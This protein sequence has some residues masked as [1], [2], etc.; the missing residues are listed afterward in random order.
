MFNGNLVKL[1]NNNDSNLR[2]NRFIDRFGDSIAFLALLSVIGSGFFIWLQIIVFDEVVVSPAQI[3][4][5][6]ALLMSIWLAMYFVVPTHKICG[7]VKYSALSKETVLMIVYFYGVLLFS[8]F[9]IVRYSAVFVGLPNSIGAFLYNY[10]L[11]MFILPFVAVYIGTFKNLGRRRWWLSKK[12]WRFLFFIALF[13]CGLQ[14]FQVV[15]GGP[16]V[17]WTDEVVKQYAL[18]GQFIKFDQIGGVYRAQGIYRSPLEAGIC[19]VFL[20]M[21]S[22]ERLLRDPKPLG[23]FVASFIC[24]GGVLATG[25]RTAYLLFGVS[26][27]S[28][29]MLEFL[30]SKKSRYRLFSY[31]LRLSPIFLI[32]VYFGFKY[33]ERKSMVTVMLNP[34]NLLIRLRNWGG[35]LDQ[36]LA[37]LDSFVFGVGK[38][39]NGNYGD[40]HSVVIDNTYIGILLTSG[41]VGLFAWIGVALLW[42]FSVN[43]GVTRRA[44]KSFVSISFFVG[45]S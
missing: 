3:K 1:A 24:A 33:L 13:S 43:R 23:W 26:V 20:L 17:M 41:I 12:V 10:S 11:I 4:L 19:G 34:E 40:Y 15:F 5:L 30:S 42:G 27:I 36:L 14:V 32:F 35:L 2:G 22:I 29:L 9:M 28:L 25:S 44:G 38:V 45:F 7:E 31:I 21:I 18:D 6:L 39:Q 16:I 8:L 37:S